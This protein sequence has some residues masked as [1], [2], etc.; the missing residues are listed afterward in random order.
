[1]TMDNLRSLVHKA[2]FQPFTVHL[3]DGYELHVPHPD[4]LALTGGGGTAV[5]TSMHGD[6]FTIVD[7]SLITRLELPAVPRPPKR[8]A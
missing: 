4:F 6:A 3:T 7:I 1:M 8:Q 2:P 5:V